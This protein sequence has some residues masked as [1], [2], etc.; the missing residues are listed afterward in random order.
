MHLFRRWSRHH[1][2]HRHHHG[3]DGR[4]D[5]FGAH[6]H[7]GAYGPLPPGGWPFAGYGGFGPW[8]AIGP[9]HGGG[10]A[11]VF[12]G[13]HGPRH[14]RGHHPGRG[15][16]FGAGLGLGADGRHGE[17][18]QARISAFLDLSDRQQAA[19]A[20][21]L[22]QLRT[23]RRALRGLMSGE[24]VA[25]LVEADTFA[26]EA[27][28][29]WLD[30]QV[31]ALRTAVPALVQA[32]GDFFDS[33]DFDQQQALRFMMRRLRQRGGRRPQPPVSDAGAAMG[34]L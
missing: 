7:A 34:P 23:R 20:Q 4:F 32:F 11:G 25:R 33:L 16:G 13:G 17:R 26:R 28:Q 24:E 10:F 31:E 1:E 21:V 9:A 12:G 2:H 29:Q 6:P 3:F 15:A 19:L 8:A 22:D 27:A 18:L 14:G 30:A 5:P